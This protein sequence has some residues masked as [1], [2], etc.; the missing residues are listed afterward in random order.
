MSLLKYI[1][2]NPYLYPAE[3]MAKF[4]N[5][6]QLNPHRL[7]LVLTEKLEPRNMVT[8][9][10]MEKWKIILFGLDCDRSTYVNCLGYPQPPQSAALAPEQE[11]PGAPSDLRTGSPTRKLPKIDLI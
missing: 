11:Q 4:T 8:L 3:A 5:D 2:P 10:V 7:Q 6:M 9:G 1:T